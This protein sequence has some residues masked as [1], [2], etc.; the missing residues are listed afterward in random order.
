L[1]TARPKPWARTSTT[2]L[3]AIQ[4]C[5]PRQCKIHSRHCQKTGC[6]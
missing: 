6:T 5:T 4:S 1:A 2:W 3:P